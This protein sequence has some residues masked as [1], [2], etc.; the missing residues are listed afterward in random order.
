MSRCT[1][2][3]AK[4][5]GRYRA[6]G[7]FA[8]RRLGAMGGACLVSLALVSLAPVALALAALAAI[9]AC[10]PSAWMCTRAEDCAATSSCVAGRCVAHGAAVAISTARRVLYDPVAVGYVRRGGEASLPAMVALGR[11][12]GA[13]AFLR[14]SV[15]LP[16]EAGVVEAYLLLDRVAAV[17]PDPQPIALHAARIVEPWDPQSLSWAVQPRVEEV[18]APVTRVLP[19][20]GAIVRLDVRELVERWRRRRGTDFGLAVVS[21]AL[22]RARTAEGA[23][24][25]AASAAAPDARPDAPQE[26]QGMAFALAAGA[27]GGERGREGRGPGEGEGP[28]AP[29]LELYLR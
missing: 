7:G 2:H 13:I 5:P 27:G 25:S 18:G 20:S 4:R 12:D 8:L 29:R 11:G 15:S 19:A 26:R 28:S 24:A 21:E 17:D 1:G 6:C 16:P 14:F 10:A 3:R 22:G 9:G 23:D